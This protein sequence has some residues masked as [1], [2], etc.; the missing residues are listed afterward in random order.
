[1]DSDDAL[2][3]HEKPEHPG[4]ELADMAQLEEPITE[5]LGQGLPMALPV[6]QLRQPGNNSGKVI[7]IRGIQSV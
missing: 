3:L 1:M 2:V 6:S 5:R 7:R 4:I